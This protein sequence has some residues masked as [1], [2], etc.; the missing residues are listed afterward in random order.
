MRSI[1]RI[2]VSALTVVALLS[3]AI[4]VRAVEISLCHASCVCITWVSGSSAYIEVRCRDGAAGGWSSG[5]T[6]PPDGGDGSWAGTGT[7]QNPPSPLPGMPLSGAAGMAVT[8]AKNTAI[9]KL[10]GEKVPDMKGV[11]LPTRCTDLF[12][13]NPLGHPGAYILGNYVVFRDG[14]GVKN[15]KNIDVCAEGNSSAWTKCC[16]HDPVVFICPAEFAAL[17]PSQRSTKL[18]HETLHVAGQFEDLDGSVGPGDPPNTSQID[19]VVN[20]ACN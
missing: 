14:T 7:S 8:S 13:A 18:I 1:S 11:W 12:A 16:Q 19:A 3:L 15:E 2:G 6:A 10:R 20:A 9:T 4:R 17:S 5:P